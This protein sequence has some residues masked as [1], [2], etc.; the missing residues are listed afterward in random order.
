MESSTNIRIQKEI[1]DA[2]F[3]EVSGRTTLSVNSKIG[4][5]LMENLLLEDA[6]K[7]V[8]F[9]MLMLRQSTWG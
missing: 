6:E 2:W 5:H 1:K 4:N 7:Y 8:K 9:R 3:Q